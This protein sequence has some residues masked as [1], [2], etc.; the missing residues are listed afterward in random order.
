MGWETEVDASR[1]LLVVGVAF[2]LRPVS[3]PLSS[4]AYL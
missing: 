3:G 2:F 1:L 4:Y